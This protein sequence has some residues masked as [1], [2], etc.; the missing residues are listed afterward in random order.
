MRDNRGTELAVGQLVAYNL[1]GQIAKGRILSCGRERRERAGGGWTYN[2]DT[3]KVELLHR[4]A[5]MWPG[6]V[7]TVRSS[8]NVLV[9]LD[10]ES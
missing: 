7:S 3:I 9:L 6:H 4:A 8:V 5:G 2:K 10:G 1:S